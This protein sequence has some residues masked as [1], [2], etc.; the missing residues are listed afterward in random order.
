MFIME[1]VTHVYVFS[2]RF[3][4]TQLVGLWPVWCMAG[5]HLLRVF[6]LLAARSLEHSTTKTSIQRQTFTFSCVQYFVRSDSPLPVI[7]NRKTTTTAPPSFQIK[8]QFRRKKNT[9]DHNTVDLNTKNHKPSTI[10][11]QVRR[12]PHTL[13]QDERRHIER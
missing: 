6:Q 1:R 2:E 7:I 12:Q 10:G 5:V 9:I 13:Q 4:C 8:D 11:Q 3:V